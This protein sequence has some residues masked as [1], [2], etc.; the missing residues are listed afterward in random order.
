MGWSTLAQMLVQNS[1][2]YYDTELKLKIVGDLAI[3]AGQQFIDVNPDMITGF[4]DFVPVD[5]TLP[6]DRF[7]QANMWRELFAQ[8][9]KIPEIMAQY[10]IGRIFEWVA[11]LAGLKNITQFKLQVLPPGIAPPPNVVPIG[12]QQIQRRG[13]QDLGRVPEPGQIS[14]LGT[15]G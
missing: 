10:N 4:Y 15:T 13:P 1:Q 8:I 12:G 3:G 2:Q 5:G 11:Q 6:I 14:G 9:S 7:A